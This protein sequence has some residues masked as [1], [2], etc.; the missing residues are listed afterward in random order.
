MSRLASEFWVKAYLKRLSLENIPAFVISHGDDTAGA[1]LVKLSTLDGRATLF[2][3][4][5][6]LDTGAQTWATLA[7]GL[8]ADVDGTIAKQRSFDPDVWV[9]EIE[10]RQ[11]RHFLDDY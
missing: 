8:E 2:H 4:S 5:F 10:D 9:V 3:R 11:G 7:A 6:D 1:V